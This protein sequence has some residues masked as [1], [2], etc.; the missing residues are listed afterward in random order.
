[1]KVQVKTE[2]RVDNQVLKNESIGIL[3]GKSLRFIEDGVTVT[4][5]FLEQSM[6]RRDSEKKLSYKFV[7]NEETLNE[8]YLYKERGS[9]S[10]PIFTECFYYQDS[11]IKIRY[12]LAEEE[13]MVCY[14]VCWEELK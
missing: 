2:L 5:N 12:R 11:S 13:Y 3:N 8:V 1:M 4:L 7:E 6:I 9:I 14:Q 10:I